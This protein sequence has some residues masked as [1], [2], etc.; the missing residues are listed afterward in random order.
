MD[1]I[2]AMRKRV[3]AFRLVSL[4]P[5]S[6]WS[7][8][9]GAPKSAANYEIFVCDFCGQ[10]LDGTMA[11]A[12]GRLERRFDFVWLNRINFPI[13]LK[14]QALTKLLSRIWAFMAVANNHSVDHASPNRI[15]HSELRCHAT[16]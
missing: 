3:P 4:R 10:T 15:R 9:D 11:Q 12:A 1:G 6:A 14:F 8:D 2:N 7:A 5:R 13:T 16:K